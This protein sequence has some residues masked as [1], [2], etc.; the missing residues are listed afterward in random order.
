[1]T[2]NA[3][4]AVQLWDGATDVEAIRFFQTGNVKIAG[5]AVRGTTEGTNHL[6]IFNG[7]SPVGTLTN[8][9]S[10]YSSS[11]D[12]FAMNAAGQANKLTGSVVF[13]EA[14][15]DLDF[16]VESDNFTH[17]F[18]VDAS[19]D[20]VGIRT[21]NV[22]GGLP[23]A[24]LHVQGNVWLEGNAAAANLQLRRYNGTVG[25]PT[26]VVSGNNIS[27][28]Q[29]SGY[30]ETTPAFNAYQAIIAQATEDWT[31]TANGFKWIFG[32]VPNTTATMV[33]RFVI[34]HDGTVVYLPSTTTPATLSNN[35]EWTLTPTSDTNFRISYKGSDGTTRVG[36]IT[37]A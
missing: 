2:V 10:L 29:V 16:R 33:P 17:A 28:I 8:G 15:D 26:K 24:P 25:S 13:N 1:M 35:G 18:F 21:S 11:G 20:F 9:I 37:L 4:I 32:T 12:F 6:D 19:T 30:Q 23:L 14:G 34:N 7:T 27:A 5:S 36:N 3:P 31:S 22:V